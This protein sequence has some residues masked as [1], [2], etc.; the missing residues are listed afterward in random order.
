MEQRRPD[1]LLLLDGGV[2]VIELKTKGSVDIADIDQVSAYARDL[3]AY[4]A[5]C[6]VEP[7]IPALVLMGATGRIGNQAGVEIVGPDAVD[8]V[9][10]SISTG[11]KREALTRTAFLDVDAYRPL[12]TI[13]EAAR[14]LM[15]SGSL[16]R[17]GRADAATAP[18]LEYLTAVAH[19]A[20][21]PKT[22]HLVLLGGLPG[23]GKTLVGLQL[24]HSR[25]LDDLA[26][27]R[28][29]PNR[30]LPRCTCLAT[31]PWSKSCNTSF[32]PPAVAARHSFA[33]SRTTSRS[34]PPL[35]LHPSRTRP[36]LRRGAARVRR[37]TGRGQALEPCTS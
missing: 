13:V 34:T 10:A 27:A 22:R 37:R 31:V 23:T 20:A 32:A 19:E 33:A 12:P 29:Q 6:A 18:T 11:G 24:A 30:R 1:V 14:Q 36:D 16:V 8:D 9:V 3:R 17:V 7:V 2:L 28:D 26:V 5:A 4:H 21:A 35:R 15:E 25:F